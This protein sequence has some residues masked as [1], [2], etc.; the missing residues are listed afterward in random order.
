MKTHPGLGRLLRW[1]L[2]LSLTGWLCWMFRDRWQ[3]VLST[4][5]LP[6]G[7]LWALAL[8]IVLMPLNWG[9]EMWKFRILLGPEVRPPL[10]HLL[11]SVLGGITLSMTLPNRLGES[12]GRLAVLP[13]AWRG[14]G[15]S[16]S[17]TGSLLQMI[18][19]LAGGMM[20]IAWGEGTAW[21]RILESLP[22]FSW[23][24]PVVT[25]ALALSAVLAIRPL[26]GILLSSWAHFKK[27]LGFERVTAAALTG[28][29]RYG[30]FILQYLILLRFAGAAS[31]LEDGIFFAAL[32]F[33]CQSVLPLPPAIGW[34]GRLQLAVLVS[35]WAGIHAG[36]AMFASLLLWMINLFL[37]GILGAAML[38]RSKPETAL[39]DA[40]ILPDRT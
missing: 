10:S 26:R 24:L 17:L 39:S 36:Q 3:D 28:L 23:W 29:L 38:W 18:W 7:P 21:A 37:P 25:L 34:V 33:F 32:V 14:A 22:A 8:A 19:I 11:R 9:L 31:R 16:A 40:Q 35:G 6:T 15:L 13:A 20:A 4:T 12:I 27:S 5:A 30:T 2:W 1:G